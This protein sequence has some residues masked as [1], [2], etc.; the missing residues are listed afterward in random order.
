[1][2][3]REEFSSGTY[4]KE[5]PPFVPTLSFAKKKKREEDVRV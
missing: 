4:V 5:P 3:R 2:G 1:M